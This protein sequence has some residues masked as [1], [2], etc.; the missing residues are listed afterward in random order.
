VLPALRNVRPD[1]APYRIHGASQ[2][3][4]HHRENSRFLDFARLAGNLA[5]LEMTEK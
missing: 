5:T 4:A 2:N 3:K 1:E